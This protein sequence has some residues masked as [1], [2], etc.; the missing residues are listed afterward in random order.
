MSRF[1]PHKPSYRY[2][3]YFY[4]FHSRDTLAAGSLLLL[5]LLRLLMRN[6]SQELGFQVLYLW[7]SSCGIWTPFGWEMD[8]KLSPDL[9]QSRKQ[10]PLWSMWNWIKHLRQT[11]SLRLLWNDGL[12]VGVWRWCLPCTVWSGSASRFRIC[13][14]PLRLALGAFCPPTHK[15][16]LW[17]GRVES[18]EGCIEV[19]EA[20]LSLTSRMP[21][22]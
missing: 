7:M 15:R 18:G 17:G 2:R 16:V 3:T 22:F 6:R 9:S 21:W 5:L 19:V 14:M 13:S 11:F 10:T 4:S 12:F 8:R 20:H 1:S